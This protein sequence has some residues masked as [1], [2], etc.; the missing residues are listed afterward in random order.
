[1][2]YSTTL[3][4]DARELERQFNRR[5]LEDSRA[6]YLHSDEMEDGER[7]IMFRK[8]TSAFARPYWP[9]LSTADPTVFDA[10]RWGFFRKNIRSE[11]EAKAYIKEW[12]SFNAIS[13]EVETKAT[14]KD[15][16]ANGQRCLIPVTSFTEW[17]HVPVPGK[18]TPDKVP[19][20]IRVKNEDIFLLGGIWQDTHLGYRTYTILTTKANPLMAVIHNTKKRQPVIIPHDMVEYW[21]SPT[22]DNDHAKLL[23]DAI[24]DR[25][26]E[27]EAA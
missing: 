20:N 6:A 17:Q 27:A 15:A 2:C 4:R 25:D 5:L 16:W 10:Y 14:Y 13:E 11:E 24:P 26:M 7:S 18:K 12:P 21:L 23:C 3:D 8:R 19:Y 9:V 22:L 1:M